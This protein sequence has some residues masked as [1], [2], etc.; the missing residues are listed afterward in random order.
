M[1]RTLLSLLL[2]AA[3]GAADRYAIMVDTN[4]TV[5][6][7]VGWSND[8]ARASAVAAHVA[9]TNEAAHNRT[10]LTGFGA[11]A[12][13]ATGYTANAAVQWL[14]NEGG[15]P[16]IAGLQWPYSDKLT[17]WTWGGFSNQL[18]LLNV[19]RTAATN[20]ASAYARSLDGQATNLSIT[21]IPLLGTNW[22]SGT[23]VTAQ[24]LGR[25][26]QEPPTVYGDGNPGD[27]SC[28]TN[29]FFIYCPDGLWRRA[30]LGLW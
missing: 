24:F 2:V 16:G 21:R 11:A 6:A 20:E 28:T 9:A 23:G 19:V 10:N 4:G 3:A 15:A 5:V 25:R 12:A 1:K 26:V 14:D 30:P 13:L 29:Y 22:L 8:V 18:Y 17:I 27:W 7:P